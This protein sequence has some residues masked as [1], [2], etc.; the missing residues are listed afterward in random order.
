MKISSRN[1]IV[2]NVFRQKKKTKKEEEE[3]APSGFE[4]SPVQNME[5]KKKTKQPLIFYV[6]N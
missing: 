1:C 2:L 5:K 6:H 3:D 4:S